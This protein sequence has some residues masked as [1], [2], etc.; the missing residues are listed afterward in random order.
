[1]LRRGRARSTSSS[2]RAGLTRSGGHVRARARERRSVPYAEGSSV[3][4]ASESRPQSTSA[5][6]VSL[7]A[8][9]RVTSRARWRRSRRAASEANRRSQHSALHQRSGG[10]IPRPRNRF[11]ILRTL[12]APNGTQR[13]P[14]DSREATRRLANLPGLQDLRC[15]VSRI[16]RP[17]QLRRFTV[18]RRS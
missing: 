7:V 9:A 10:L 13:R 12:P 18:R 3:A 16:V 11:R 14:P 2:R 15:T 4:H 17:N 5:A 6:S 1:M 8:S